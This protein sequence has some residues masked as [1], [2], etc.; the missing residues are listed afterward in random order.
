VI[1]REEWRRTIRAEARN[2]DGPGDDRLWAPE[3]D[4]APAEQLHA[5]QSRKL[6][7]GVEWMYDRSALFRAK[8][9]A[10]GL[11]PGDVRSVEDLGKLPI[12]RKE[13]MSADV[14]SNPPYGTFQSLT[15]RE[16]I[17]H[18][19]QV[20]Q[21]SGTT[22]APRAFRYSQFDRELWSWNNARALYAMGIRGGRDVVL[23]CFGYG[24]HV[25]MWGMHY[26]LNL[27]GVPIVPG[28]VDSRTRAH[29]IDRYGVT[30]LFATPS[31]LLYLA[32][33]MRQQ[34]LDPASSTVERVVTGGEPVPVTTQE[35]I[36]A[37]WNAEVHQCYGCTEAAPSC[38]GYT[39][40]A[41]DWLHFMDDTHV[42]EA[43]DPE[44][45]EPVPDGQAGLSVV[46]NLFSDSSPQ[47]RF[48]VGD[49][50]RLTHEPCGCGRSHVRALGGFSG[51]ADE[52]LNIRGVTLF[53][54]AIEHLVRGRV[55]LGAEFEIVLAT[56]G[57]LDEIDLV[58][59]AAA[60]VPASDYD[61]VGRSLADAF[62]ARL[63]LRPSVTVVAPDTLPKTEFKARRVR[64]ERAS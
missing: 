47:I 46:T 38:G 37:A 45:M 39:C 33:V 63:E 2:T 19:W 55:E 43:V 42:L 9:E 40:G 56:R 26:A 32:D 52:M 17:E 18:G 12:T 4:A 6:V 57:G 14:E 24:P 7:A 36:A 3:L 41:G 35:R 10:T 16:W 58:V 44:T 31:Y 21:T 59:E 48:L 1:T 15:E 22:G 11:E 34:G 13:E 50:T 8:C 23:L 27:M 64:D 25:F 28:G 60:T 61:A 54:S 62:R 20:F 49:Y 51:R 30:V 5:V 53:P 29:M